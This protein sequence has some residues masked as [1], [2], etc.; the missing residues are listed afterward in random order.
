MDI[1]T[2]LGLV[3]AFGLIVMAIDDMSAFID[4]SSILIVI[5]GSIMVVMCAL[6]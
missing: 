2:I 1:A 5:G 4:T 6:H 3:G